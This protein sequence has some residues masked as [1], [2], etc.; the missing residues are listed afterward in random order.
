MRHIT[1]VILCC[2]S[3]AD[4]Q[5]PAKSSSGAAQTKSTPGTATKAAP[6]AAPPSPCDADAANKLWCFAERGDTN[7]VK[8]M[9][10]QGTDVNAIGPKA[11]ASALGTAA[12]MGR[13]DTVEFLLHHGADVN[14]GVSGY[15]STPLITASMFGFTRIVKL[16]IDSGAEVN[17]K[18]ANGS[19]PLYWASVA[20]NTDVVDILLAHGADASQQAKQDQYWLRAQIK[21]IDLEAKRIAVHIVSGSLP[22]KDTPDIVFNVSKVRYFGASGLSELKPNDV[23]TVH[24][25]G[26]LALGDVNFSSFGAGGALD[27]VVDYL[28]LLPPN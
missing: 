10:A 8:L 4:A 20:G 11:K 21:A 9:L 27:F 13:T 2:V 23:A 12:Q 5:Q 18:D 22:I 1:A 25:H 26:T 14:L 3:F 16:L 6:T 19:S 7:G 28:A 17:R 15:A 24:Y